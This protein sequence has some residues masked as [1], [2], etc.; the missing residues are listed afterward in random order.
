MPW[1]KNRET[2]HILQLNLGQSLRHQAAC[3][4]C[5]WVFLC[6][7]CPDPSSDAI[8]SVEIPKQIDPSRL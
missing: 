6:I 1:C 5:K 2:N 3:V 8:S 7:I 4:G